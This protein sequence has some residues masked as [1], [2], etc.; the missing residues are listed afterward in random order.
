MYTTGAIIEIM[1]NLKYIINAIKVY[2]DVMYGSIC[3]NIIF[4][5]QAHYDGDSVPSRYR[6]FKYGFNYNEIDKIGNALSTLIYRL[7]KFWREL[8]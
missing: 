7:V 5:L 2:S 8:P 6:E 3:H 4:T 1:S